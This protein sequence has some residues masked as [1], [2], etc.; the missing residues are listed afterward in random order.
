MTTR[1]YSFKKR[2]KQKC[3]TFKSRISSSVCDFETS[4]PSSLPRFPF[5]LIRRRTKMKKKAKEEKKNKK[6]K[7][8]STTAFPGKNPTTDLMADSRRNENTAHEISVFHRASQDTP[9]TRKPLSKN[10][11]P[12]RS[13]RGESGG[14][15]RSTTNPDSLISQRLLQ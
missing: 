6:N 8:V 9:T 4:F 2:Y 1:V 11:A 3:C 5:L 10:G 14:N 13:Q 7:K 12:G 15:A